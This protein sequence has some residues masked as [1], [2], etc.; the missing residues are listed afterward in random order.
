MRAASNLDDVRLLQER[1]EIHA[2]SVI[3]D[4]R[5]L[6]LTDVT[7]NAPSAG[8]SALYSVIVASTFVTKA[9]KGQ[10]IQRFYSP[11]RKSSSAQDVFW[12][13]PLLVKHPTSRNTLARLSTQSGPGPRVHPLEVPDDITG[14]ITYAQMDKRTAHQK[15]KEHLG[16]EADR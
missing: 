5:A 2:N 9:K 1:F 6:Q 8:G 7:G 11:R 14:R 4:C 12:L 10:A 16:V 3:V 15:R 13:C